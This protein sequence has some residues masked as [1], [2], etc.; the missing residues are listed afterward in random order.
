[1]RDSFAINSEG[2]MQLVSGTPRD[3]KLREM[4]M[5]HQLKQGLASLPKPK[6]SEWELELPE[7][8]QELAKVELSEEDAEL[9]DRRNKQIREAQELLERKRQTQVIQR[10]LPR[11]AL[12]DVDAILKEASAISDPIQASIAQEVSLLLANDAA[13]HPAPGLKL[14]GH[15]KQLDLFEDDTLAQARLSIAQE[16]SRDGSVAGAEIFAKTWNELHSSSLVPALVDYEDEEPSE[17]ELLMQAFEVSAPFPL[18]FMP[19]KLT[20][21]PDCP[22][23]N[24]KHC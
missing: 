9:R 19:S 22:E 16:V 23:R 11:P 10:G 14:K 21:I 12:V 2:D 8:Q 5:K 24:H 3:M 7:E 15:A 18:S 1:M 6:D 20:I 4:A 13:K 17:R